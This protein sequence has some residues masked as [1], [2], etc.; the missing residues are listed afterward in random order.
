MKKTIL[1]RILLFAVL[2][3]ILVGC[4]VCFVGCDGDYIKKASKDLSTYTI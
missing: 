4:S 3:A 2:A 1:K